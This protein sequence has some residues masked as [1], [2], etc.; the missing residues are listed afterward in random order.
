MGIRGRYLEARADI[1]SASVPVTSSVETGTTSSVKEH[2]N[3]DSHNVI[4]YV[5]HSQFEPL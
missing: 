1:P 2:M 5:Y 3:K 4:L